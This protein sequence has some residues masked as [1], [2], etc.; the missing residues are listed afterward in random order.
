MSLQVIAVGNE[1]KLPLAKGDKVIYQRY[2]TAEVEVP[3][4]TVYFVAEKSIMAKL[5]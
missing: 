5:H 4:G 1:V 3:E 2:A